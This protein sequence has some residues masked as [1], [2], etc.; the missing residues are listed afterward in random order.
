MMFEGPMGFSATTP[1]SFSP[2]PHTAGGEAERLSDALR[3]SPRLAMLGVWGLE[4][5]TWS[6]KLQAPSILP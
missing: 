4:L 2:L 5:G 3:G 1:R 6:S